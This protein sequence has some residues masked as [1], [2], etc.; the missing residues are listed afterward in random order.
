M[1][2]G[3]IAVKEQMLRLL[4]VLTVGRTERRRAGEREMEEKE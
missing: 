2:A 1:G 3:V 4:D